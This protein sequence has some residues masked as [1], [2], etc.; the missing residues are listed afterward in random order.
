MD[1]VFV[2]GPYRLYPTARILQRDGA[3]VSIGSRAF[4]VLVA[5]VQRSGQVVS[6]REL[7]TLAWPGLFVDDSN[8]RVQMANLRR[9]LGSVWTVLAISWASPGADIVSCHRFTG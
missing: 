2:F 3:P 8:V 4:D 9:E 5:L 1:G 6:R 7:M